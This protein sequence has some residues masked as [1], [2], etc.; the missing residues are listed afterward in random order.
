HLGTKATRS[1]ILETLYHRGYIKDKK[2]EATPLGMSLIETM[3]KHS[4]III[5]EKLTRTFEDEM[6]QIQNSK[7]D[8]DKKEQKVV[9]EAKDT[10]T[11]IAKQ[12]E[13][14]EKEIG[15]ELLVAN[16]K[17]RE[18]QREENRL[19]ICPVCKKGNLI[20]TYSKKTERHFV[21]CDSYPRCKTTFSLPPNGSIKRA[22]K[23][24]DQCGF[25]KLLLLK[26]GKKP[27]TFCFNPECATNKERIEKYKK[28]KEG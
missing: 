6:E 7:K 1:S 28:R 2:I 26:R 18:Q 23:V 11:K 8:L 15:I 4:P 3:E 19:N 12:F 20:V 16:V 9:E 14:H 13:E 22:E 24:C 10:I 25:P 21:A 27:W 5:D 17:L